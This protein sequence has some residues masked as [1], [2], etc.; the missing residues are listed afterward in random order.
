M[1]DLAL[2]PMS[3]IPSESAHHDDAPPTEDGRPAGGTTPDGPATPA[4]GRGITRRVFGAIVTAVAAMLVYL[5]LIVPDT[6]AHHSDNAFVPGA[7]VRLPMEA[8]LGGAV[9][10]VVP[11]RWRRLTAAIMGGGLGVLVVL[12]VANA[13]F[14]MYLGRR[15]NPVLDWTLLGDGYN[16]LTETNGH[17]YATTVAV[18][19]VVLTVVVITLMTLSAV[20]LGTVTARH[21]APARR[22]LVALSAVWIVLALTGV[23]FFPGNPVAADSTAAL[24]KSTVKEI[25][26]AIR[27]QA[28]FNRAMD[29]DAYV[30]VPAK[31]RLAALTGKDFVIGVVESYG[32]SALQDPKMS[33]LV[34]PVLSAGTQQLA[35][36]GF[37]AKSGFLTSS[38]YGGGSWLAHGSFQSGLWIDS[39]QRY[40]QLISSNRLTIT[41]AFHEAGWQTYGL[42]PGN[43]TAWPEGKFYG[44]D[45]VY[46]SRNLSYQGPAFGWSR[47]P[48]QYTLAQFQKDV[49]GKPHA[50]LMAEITMTSSH[51]PW[52]PLPK[53]VDWNTIGD[54][55]IYGPM[56]RQG[57]TRTQL[58]QSPQATQ[59]AYATSVAYSVQSLVSWVEKYGDKNLVLV[60]FGDHQPASIVSGNNASHDV[61]VT[62]IA[63]D[64]AV[65]DRIAD[66]GWQDG[67]KPNPQAPVWLMDSFRDKFFAAF[68]GEPAR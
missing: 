53:F 25:P 31:Q 23:T 66:W 19:A 14:L 55:T 13:G 10:I 60:M 16:A 9:L 26:A 27:D 17:T 4:A 18:G 44:Y 33:A 40:R 58:W 56:A 62:I 49:Y 45:S 48:D 30:N 11:G 38:T 21:A 3:R 35:A 65:L 2:P 41:K 63:H 20:R 15:F 68:G 50:P 54:G 36:K 24:A 61:P 42:E 32:R 52:T 57:E 12:K 64:P 47:M 39:P 29:T 28:T 37:H 67:L 22:A 8:I 51:N 34:D 7:F 59:L 6:I 5:G 46:D 1:K 43:T